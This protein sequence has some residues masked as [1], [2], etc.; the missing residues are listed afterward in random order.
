[1]LSGA[2]TRSRIQPKFVRNTP[3]RI[4][5]TE[6]VVDPPSSWT[7]Y[8]FP[9]TPALYLFYYVDKHLWKT[10]PFWWRKERLARCLFSR[11]FPLLKVPL[12]QTQSSPWHYA[13]Q[14]KLLLEYSTIGDSKLE[15]I[16]DMKC[17]ESRCMISGIA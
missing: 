4:R 13:E 1:M 8:I 10:V 9:A 14:A 7:S 16:S 15:E 17:P 3:Y 6:S 5:G 11:P 12:E 2:I